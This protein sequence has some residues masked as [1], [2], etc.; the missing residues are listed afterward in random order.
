[1]GMSDLFKL[2]VGTTNEEKWVLLSALIPV[3]QMVV[4]VRNISLDY[5]GTHFKTDQ[6]IK[7][8]DNGADNCR[9]NLNN[10]PNDQRILLAG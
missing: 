2:K 3:R 10:A 1:M 6:K 8:I 9:C 4:Q 7:W 5:D